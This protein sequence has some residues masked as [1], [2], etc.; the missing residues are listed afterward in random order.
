MFLIN[1]KIT[2][3]INIF[4]KSSKKIVN[5]KVMKL[6]S[7]I[8]IHRELFHNDLFKEC[9]GKHD[10]IEIYWV[11]HGVSLAP[12]FAASRQGRGKRASASSL[13]HGEILVRSNY[14]EMATSLRFHTGTLFSKHTVSVSF[15]RQWTSSILFCNTFENLATR[16]KLELYLF[17]QFLF[18][19]WYKFWYCFQLNSPK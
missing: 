16:E 4:Y 10:F 12:V 3:V 18:F 5:W 8:K 13:L 1:N 6:L 14:D 15:G 9:Y 19:V 11:Y 2:Y 17:N 7:I